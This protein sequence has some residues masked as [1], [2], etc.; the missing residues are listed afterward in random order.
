MEL[1]LTP[2]HS[3]AA[4]AGN[5]NQLAIEK[6]AQEFEALFLAQMLKPMFESARSESL[7][8]SGP[9]QDAYRTMLNDEFAKSIAARGGIGIADDVKAALIR[10]QANETN[11]TPKGPGL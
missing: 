3:S 4:N 2:P 11:L 6:K 5:P 9:E 7:M 10:M 1:T 8:G